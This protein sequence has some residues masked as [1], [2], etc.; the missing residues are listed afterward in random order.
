MEFLDSCEGRQHR[1]MVDFWICVQAFKQR[2]TEEGAKL[3]GDSFLQNEAI[4]IYEK[5]I[6]LQAPSHLGFGTNI[7]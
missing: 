5:F 2:A 4:I 1:P 3:S 6:S 7:R